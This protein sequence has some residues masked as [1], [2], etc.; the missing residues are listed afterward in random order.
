MQRIRGE[1]VGNQWAD[2][3]KG[4]GRFLYRCSATHAYTP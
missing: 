4:M 2:A 3:D 1:Q